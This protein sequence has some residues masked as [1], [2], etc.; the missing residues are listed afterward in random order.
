M[1][2]VLSLLSYRVILELYDDAVILNVVKGFVTP[3]PR[4]QL[5]L[6]VKLD[7]VEV[8]LNI[9]LFEFCTIF[10]PILLLQLISK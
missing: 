5:L 2:F 1:C 9:S 8:N 3:I 10:K 4:K 7:V 6:T